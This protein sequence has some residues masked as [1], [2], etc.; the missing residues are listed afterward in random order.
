MLV[1]CGGWAVAAA[2]DVQGLVGE[3]VGHDPLPDP[4]G[5]QGAGGEGVDGPEPVEVPSFLDKVY[6][7]YQK[8]LEGLGIKA[9]KEDAFS[10]KIDEGKVISVTPTEAPPGAEVTVIVSK[11]PEQVAVPNLKGL[12][13]DDAAA[14]LQAAGL[15]VGDRFGPP[16]RPVFDSSP[17]AGTKVDKGSTVDVY[18]R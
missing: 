5:G 15:R 9:K 11:G 18:T 17:S 3:G 8:L 14:K 2:S 6:D 12:S 13:E 10:D 16:N 1:Q 4:A 7:E